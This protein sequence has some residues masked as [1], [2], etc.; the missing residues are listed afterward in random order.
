MRTNGAGQAVGVV[1][2]IDGRVGGWL[3]E[4]SGGRPVGLLPWVGLTLL[5]VTAVALFGIEVA[6][7]LPAPVGVPAGVVVTLTG[8]VAAPM[9]AG[10]VVHQGPASA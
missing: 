9:V 5:M 6:A 2:R 10:V 8:A 7:T 1:R 3:E 4:V